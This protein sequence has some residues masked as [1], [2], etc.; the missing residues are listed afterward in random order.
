[1]LIAVSLQFE[2]ASAVFYLPILFVFSIWQRQKLPKSKTILICIVL[3]LLTL[4]PQIIFNF[5]HDNLIVNSFHRVLVS[6]NSFRLDVAEVLLTRLDYFWQV[7]YSKIIPEA[8]VFVAIMTFLSLFSIFSSAKAPMKEKVIPLF[9]IF[10][11][12]PII[13]YTLFQGNFGNIFD[14]YMSG[15][16]LPMILLFSIGLSEFMVNKFTKIVVLIFFMIFLHRNTTMLKS[17]LTSDVN[18]EN[19]I[20][21]VNQIKAVDYILDDGKNYGE[22]NVDFYVPPVIP[23]AYDYLF[24][25]HGGKKCGRDI[26]GLVK[27]REV[28]VFYTPHETDNFHPERLTEWLTKQ[29]SA[30][31]VVDQE[32]F[33]G[34][35]VQRRVRNK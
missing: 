24:L 10:L 33:A 19:T 18:G 29:D 2:S 14:Y 6:E 20:T 31:N 34:I 11:L 16:Y 5:R 7:F 30:G 12:I 13:F 35:T 9:L 17:Y 3:F 23:Y 25:W 8:S 22:F 26:C 15:Y 1:M 4:I 28:S 27:N 21:L 32:S